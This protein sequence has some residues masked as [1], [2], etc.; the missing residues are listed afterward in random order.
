M[1]SHHVPGASL[2]TRS[3][4]TVVSAT[5]SL[6]VL[7]VTASVAAADGGPA[8]VILNVNRELRALG[9]QSLVLTTDADGAIDRLQVKNGWPVDVNGGLVISH[10]VHAP[11]KAKSS[12]G[13]LITLLWLTPRADVI[14]VHGLYLFS[15]LMASIVGKI[16]RTPVFLQPHGVLEPY[17]RQT[18]PRIKRLYDRLG[19]S[20]ALRSA[21]GVLFASTSEAEHA[22]DLVSAHKAVIVPLGAAVA[23]VSLHYVPSWR[24]RVDA[25]KPIILFLGRVAPKKRLD[26]LV[27]C[28]P[29]VA[30]SV[31]ATLVIA[32]SHSE[33]DR[34]ACEAT[35]GSRPD[36]VWL[37]SVLGVDRDALLRQATL[38][39]LPSENENFAI[40]VA[41]SL[42]AGTPVVVTREVA[43]SEV[44]A[45]TGSG[46][47]LS[48]VPTPTELADTL[49]AVLSDQGELERMAKA[50]REVAAPELSW[51][52]T[53]E[54]LQR[55][56]A[57]ACRTEPGGVT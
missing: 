3:L 43:M 25:G 23:E 56:Y 48:K 1:T 15:S 53:A 28:W 2:S 55:V 8:T 27:Q 40:A 33:A 41:E 7:Q 6:C 11:R 51:R 4:L 9:V 34:L 36:V 5:G 31:G 50:A 21:Q 14:H 46:V 30:E 45:R 16:F 39:V 49:V 38:F 29:R 35:T 18:S 37:G 13:L 20:W 17:Q 10:R 19:G 24:D 12:L 32:G 54:S 42:V 22:R 47:V 26:L 52:G 57:A 44:V